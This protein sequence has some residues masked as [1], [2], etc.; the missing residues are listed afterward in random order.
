MRGEFRLNHRRG[1]GHAKLSLLGE[2]IQT[3]CLLT[4]G[5][6]E[7][8]RLKL[9]VGSGVCEP[10][11]YETFFSTTETRPCSLLTSVPVPVSDESKTELGIQRAV[12]GHSVR[13][14]FL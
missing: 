4:L 11:S 10:T 14:N 2:V 12:K 5:G 9:R 7:S 6:T 13:S 3:C 1:E 8:E